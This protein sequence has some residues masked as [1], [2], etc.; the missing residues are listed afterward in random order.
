MKLASILLISVSLIC[1]V[2]S[3]PA[4]ATS[5]YGDTSACKTY[6]KE[7][8]A[9]LHSCVGTTT[10]PCFY[11]SECN[12]GMGSAKSVAY[13]QT[14]IDL[15]KTKLK[16]N[17]H[18]GC[19]SLES[20]VPNQY[21]VADPAGKIACQKVKRN[22]SKTDTSVCTISSDLSFCQKCETCNNNL[23]PTSGSSHLEGSTISESL[24]KALCSTVQQ[25]TGN[26]FAISILLLGLILSASFA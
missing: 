24:W 12:T 4:A 16:D 1:T 26:I 22:W 8:A 17:D 20:E 2:A 6:M 25:S 18:W 14:S 10:A 3:T 13:K 21:S 9:T 7:D 15:L 23:Y 11:C 19:Y 5:L